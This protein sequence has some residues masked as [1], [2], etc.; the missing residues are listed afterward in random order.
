[1]TV[2]RSF[3]TRLEFGVVC[4][5]QL[6]FLLI[7]KLRVVAKSSNC[8]TTSIS[9]YLKRVLPSLSLDIVAMAD[10]LTKNKARKPG[11]NPVYMYVST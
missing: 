9:V 3:L 2:S 5:K 4:E 7:G 11:E 1:M 6:A 10:Q 8:A